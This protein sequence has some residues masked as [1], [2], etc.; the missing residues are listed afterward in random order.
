MS[1]QNREKLTPCPQNVRTGSTPS[2]LAMQTHHKFRKIRSFLLQ[3]VRTSA[4]EESPL[5]ALDKLPPLCR[6]LLWTAPYVYFRN[7]FIHFA[8]RTSVK[9]YISQTKVDIIDVRYLNVYVG[10]GL[11][12]YIQPKIAGLEYWVLFLFNF[13]KTKLELDEC[14]R[15]QFESSVQHFCLFTVVSS[16]PVVM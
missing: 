1:A 6:R 5:S 7:G 10:S 9:S 4:S 8:Q 2:P 12:P 15:Y 14:I 11:S 13:T 16:Y 3:K